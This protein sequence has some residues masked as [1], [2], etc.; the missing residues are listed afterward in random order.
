MTDRFA[1]RPG[2]LRVPPRPNFDAGLYFIG[3]ICTPW[4]TIAD[5]PKNSGE[6]DAICTIELDARYAPGLKDVETCTHL[7]VLYWMGEAP[8]DLIVQK[9]RHYGVPHGV[10]ALR[11]PARP[12]PIAM[13]VVELQAIEGASLQVRG[14][15]CLDGTPLLDI[16]PYFASIDAKPTA[17]VGWHESR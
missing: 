13:S 4:R 16:K 7:V 15:D 6:A 11:S 17:R 5:C 8:R 10:F 1:P 2:E 3:R 14:L 9:P 12:N